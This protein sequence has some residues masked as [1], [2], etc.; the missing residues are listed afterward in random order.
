MSSL[1]G[2]NRTKY[3]IV[4]TIET[5]ELLMDNGPLIF[6]YG[7]Y[8]ERHW[9]PVIPFTLLRLPGFATIHGGVYQH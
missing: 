9:A 4:S 7:K 6:T 5:N 3:I 8:P 2:I 1:N